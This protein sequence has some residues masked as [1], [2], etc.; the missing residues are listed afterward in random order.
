MKKYGSYMVCNEYIKEVRHFLKLFFEE[1][2]DEYT[3][4][5]WKTFLMPGS[6]LKVNLM[7]D[8]EQ[9]ITQNMTFEIYCES[10]EE[11][12]SLAEKHNLK[13]DS[14]LS[15]RS[16]QNYKYHFIEIFGP[17]NICKIEIN[18]VENVS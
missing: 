1:L 13:I 16:S 10:L 18:F 4:E 6:K 14:F 5:D 17:H 15:T 9:S 8:K 11:L 12:K 3:S 7:V 2:S